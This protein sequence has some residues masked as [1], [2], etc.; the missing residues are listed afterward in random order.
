MAGATTAPADAVAGKLAYDVHGR[1]GR[2]YAVAANLDGSNQR[3]L[4]PTARHGWRDFGWSP[5]GTRFAAGRTR[6]GIG[7]GADAIAV[8]TDG[9]GTRFVTRATRGTEIWDVSWSPDSSMLAFVRR[10]RFACG[11][12]SLWVVR[13][14][15]TGVR[16]LTRGTAPGVIL[17]IG[18]WSPDGKH[19]AYRTMTYVAGDCRETNLRGSSLLTIATEGSRPQRLA[20][21]ADHIWDAAWSPDGSRIAYLP[22]EFEMELPCQ[23]WL[24]DATGQHP[25]RISEPVNGFAALGIDWT[26]DG[27]EL[28]V[29]YLCAPQKCVPEAD[30]CDAKTWSAG[31]RAIDPQTGKT[32]SIVSRPGCFGAMVLAIS[33]TIGSIGFVWSSLDGSPIGRPMLVAT[34]GSGLQQLPPPP[35][36]A[37]ARVDPFPSLY[38]P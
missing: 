27:R 9:G 19:L 21:G 10:N 29:P 31:L 22:C 26:P 13:S 1:Q 33:R 14:D 37:G 5:D 17:S 30:Y 23:P 2:A 4:L 20:K 25:H 6:S 32:R 11:G 38:L 18:D 36:V 8:A 35:K 28:V 15:G 7:I 12:Y 24:V 16:R 3:R 34:D